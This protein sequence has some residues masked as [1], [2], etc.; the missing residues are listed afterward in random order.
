MNDKYIFRLANIG[1][2]QQIQELFDN[3]PLPGDISVIFQRRPSYFLGSEIEARESQVMAC[4]YGGKII[5][6]ISR[7]LNKLYINGRICTIGYLGSLRV[8]KQHQ[9]KGILTR[10]WEYLAKLDA[11]NKA[12]F[13]ISSIIADNKKAISIFTK[14]DRNH[15]RPEFQYYGQYHTYL[16]HLSRVKKQRA[17][18]DVVIQRGTPEFL[19]QIVEY[20]QKKSLKM[21]FFPYYDR[22]DFLDDKK[23][24]R[25][26][27]IQDFYLALRNA[28]I[29]GVVSKW[30]QSNFKQTIVAEYSKKIKLA[31]P[32][33]NLFSKL[34]GSTPLPK[35][36]VMLRYF[37]IATI[38]IDDND[39]DILKLLLENVYNDNVGTDYAYFVLGLHADNPLISAVN[40]YRYIDYKSNIYLAYYGRNRDVVRQLDRSVPYFEASRL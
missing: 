10:G 25:D 38:V 12:P 34:N 1:D 40:D 11:D 5:G 20:V 8:D 18:N 35:P 31:K 4:E 37:Y 14:S 9:G 3:N 15:L 27:K 16:I 24:F 21:Q 30:D 33:W 17:D 7:S 6:I 19:D 23:Y 2:D 32:I 39:A 26:F 28:K 36:G 13:Y 22:N 29:V